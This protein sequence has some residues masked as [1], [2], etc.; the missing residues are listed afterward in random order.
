M[1]AG[2]HAAPCRRMFSS[3][4][5]EGV[6]GVARLGRRP[7]ILLARNPGF[8]LFA[9]VKDQVGR[10]PPEAQ[11]PQATLAHRT[12]GD[13]QLFVD[14]RT[15]CFDGRPQTRQFVDDDV[16]DNPVREAAVLVAQNVADAAHS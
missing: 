16:P 6:C 12:P 9:S 10:P 15:Y 7:R 8:S 3:R 4:E 13:A 5:L 11:Q 1:P 14:Q 2:S